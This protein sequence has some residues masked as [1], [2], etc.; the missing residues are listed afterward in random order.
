SSSNQ[1]TNWAS[2][3]ISMG[4][5]LKIYRI[6]CNHSAHPLYIDRVSVSNS[7]ALSNTCKA[8]RIC[9]RQKHP[10]TAARL[11][12]STTESARNKREDKFDPRQGKRY[13]WAQRRAKPDG[14]RTQGWSGAGPVVS[15]R[16][17]YATAHRAAPCRAEMHAFQYRQTGLR[18]RLLMTLHQ[19]TCPFTTRTFMRIGVD[20]RLFYH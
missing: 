10:F 19:A 20:T 13:N 2:C 17:S 14:L 3:A 7:S 8:E 9:M 15:T 5:H 16:L 11:G 18:G 4:V 6:I 12:A 1:F